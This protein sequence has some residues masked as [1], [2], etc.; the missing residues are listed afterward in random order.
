MEAG[1]RGGEL[2]AVGEPVASATS[3]PKAMA[4]ARRG[5]FGA[6]TPWSRWRCRR[7]GEQCRE[8]VDQLQWRERQRRGAIMRW[9]GQ[10]VDNAFDY[11]PLQT[12]EREREA[13]KII[14]QPPLQPGA[15][16]RAHAHRGIE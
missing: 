14:A 13:G 2:A 11:E 6:S 8:P 12:L 7:A 9:F 16:V 10:S 1:A 4:A 5:A 15:I 3:R